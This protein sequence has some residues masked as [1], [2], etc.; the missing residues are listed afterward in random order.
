MKK[1]W[2]LILIAISLFLIEIS[3]ELTTTGMFLDGLVYSNLAANMAQGICTFWHPSISE[4]F[5]STFVGHPP[6]A[7]G[8]L[9][10][11]YKFL[12]VHI[13]VAKAYSL[14]M[15]LLSGILLLRL[16]VRL[17]FKREMGWLPLLLWALV[18]LVPQYACDNMLEGTM[19]VFVLASVLCLLHYPVSIFKKVGWHLLSGLFLY[20]AFLTKGFTG[21][22]PICLPVII[23]LVELLFHSEEKHYTFLKSLILSLVPLVSLTLCIVI[24]GLAQP[25]AFTYFKAYLSEQ[26]V[27]GIGVV[28][29]S[30]RW[31]IVIK[32]FERT[33]ILW[34]LTIFILGITYLSKHKGDSTLISKHNAKT[35]LTFTLLTLSG[36]IPMM[37]STKQSDFYILTVFPFIAVAIGAL[38]ND[39]VEEWLTKTG[40]RFQSIITTA[41]ILMVLIAL[42]TN[43]IHVGKPGRDVE[44]QHDVALITSQLQQGEHIAIPE[45]LYDQYSLI[46]YAYRAKQ[47]DMRPTS[48]DLPTES[49]PLHLLTLSD[50]ENPDPRYHEVE[51]PT[52]QYKLYELAQ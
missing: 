28:T 25:A 7:F 1:N 18:P 40:K 11:C 48:F 34:V 20:L 17:G 21:L 51:L 39:K 30:S 50:Q 6:L 49:L 33:A 15:F 32:F 2:P 4:S 42:T 35:F 43:I 31:Y 41:A 14:F 47:I 16:W 5:M 29:V 44:I 9:A 10:L 13:W 36:V 22:Y 3:N 24:V 38:L 23:W 45:S 8:L 19:G 52:H 37:I 46:N 26:I 27:S 12:G